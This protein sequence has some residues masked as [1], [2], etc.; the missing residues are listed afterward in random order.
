[1]HVHWHEGLFLQPHHLQNMQ[2]CL[3][4]EFRSSR[5]LLTPFHHGVIES[6]VSQDD[7]ADGR[8]R[9]ERLRAIMPSGVE[10][11]YPEDAELPA[12]PIKAELAR[13]SG[14]MELLLAIPLWTKNRA[15]AFRPGEPVDP[16]VKLLYVPSEVRDVADENT[17]ENP[18]PIYF[19]K[20]NARIVLKDEDV[21]DM[22]VL[23]LMRIVRATGED[24]GRPR[25]DP[26]FVPPC[27]FLNS[28]PTLHNLMRDLLAQLNASRNDVQ[29]RLSTGGLGMEVKWELTLR[30]QTLNR[31]C[32]SLPGFIEPGQIPPFVIHQL[33]RELLGELLA[34]NPQKDAFACAPYSHEDVLPCFRE[35][36]RKIRAEIRVKG[37]IEPMKVLF[38]G[39]P[40]GMLAQLEQQHFDK[41]TGYYLGIKTRIE[42]SKLAIYV[43]DPNKFKLMPQSMK[44][45]AVLGVALQ[46]EGSPPLD[47]PSQGDLHYFR[48]QPDSNARRWDAIK[49]E[50]AMALVWNNSDLD[51]SDASFTLYMTLPGA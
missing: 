1:M 20:V 12:L 27:V 13:G 9:F 28:S 42:R 4:Q 5:T 29:S 40:G 48:L 11:R 14:T 7:L 24:S 23:P 34:L 33:L 35:L 46:E 39:S 51:L 15:N 10:V 19:R 2:R 26:E 49:A 17:G 16:R 6:R 41:A 30:L 43:K 8:V 25:L 45:V 44:N 37:T 32:A 50:K 21:S 31:F 18:Q 47:L 22:E 38:S 3:Q 36:D